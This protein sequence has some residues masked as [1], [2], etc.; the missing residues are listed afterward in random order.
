[1]NR[2]EDTELGNIENIDEI[3]S[4]GD[5]L[6]PHNGQQGPIRIS[7]EMKNNGSY[8][9]SDMLNDDSLKNGVNVDDPLIEDIVNPSLDPEIANDT[10]NEIMS[11]MVPSMNFE[12]L[13]HRPASAAGFYNAT[14]DSDQ[15]KL[16]GEP[17]RSENLLNQPGSESM[18]AG[19]ASV[20]K[21][22]LLMRPAIDKNTKKKIATARTRPAFVNKLWSM[23]NDKSNQHYIHWSSNGESI[24]VPNREKFVKEVLPKYFKHS[25]FASF[26]RQLNMYGWHKV[27][28]VRSGSILSNNDSRWEFENEHFKRGKEDLLENIIR[29]K[30][31]S[32]S[33]GTG[34][35]D[36]IDIHILL[37]ELETIKYNQLAIA[38]DLKRISKDNDLLWKEN[39]LARERHQSQKQTLEKIL[40]FLSSVFGP[41]SSKAITSGFQ[42]DLIHD[43]S[44]VQMNNLNHEEDPMSSVFGSINPSDHV[45]MPAYDSKM[46]PRLLLKNRSMSNSSSTPSERKGP[47]HLP[48]N[49]STTNTNSQIIREIT[50]N[51]M[52]PASPDPNFLQE[53]QNNIDRQ[54]ESIQEIQDWI[55]KISPGEEV[56]TPIF[57]ELSAATN[58][59]DTIPTQSPA[60]SNKPQIEEIKDSA[61]HELEYN[62]DNAGSNRKRHKI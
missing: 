16:L 8:E 13:L 15:S 11:P 30:P 58:L 33:S 19:N 23:V 44:D 49:S 52:S 34:G 62:S 48:R 14:I 9:L 51:V 60:L 20:N 5:I 4:S 55:T 37:N 7:T 40:R 21:K 18:D 53:L 32:T 41:N 2:G 27:Q 46:R 35:N 26:V 6:L 59:P 56:G 39:M 22:R 61:I 10:G 36:E 1:M 38:E 29:Q 43:L 50:P 3:A 24:V 45:N 31:N 47:S 17:L 57:P 25:N 28:D 54:E 12:Q 42:P